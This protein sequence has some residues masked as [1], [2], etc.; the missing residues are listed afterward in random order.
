MQVGPASI[1]ITASSGIDDLRRLGP[2]HLAASVA[3]LQNGETPSVLGAGLTCSTT[4]SSASPVGSYPSSCSGAVDAN[5]TISYV[6]A[7]STSGPAA[8]S[9]TAS[10]GSTTYGGTPPDHHGHR[11]PAS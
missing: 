6:T 2:G 5:Y 11:T 1:T 3:G 9:I 4:A 10:S 7:R 8:L